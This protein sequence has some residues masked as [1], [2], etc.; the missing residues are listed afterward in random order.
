MIAAPVAAVKHCAC[1]HSYQSYRCQCLMPVSAW[2][3]AR[4][5][6]AGP[7]DPVHQGD[8]ADVVTA[9]HH[10]VGVKRLQLKSSGPSST[11]RH[12][13]SSYTAPLP[14]QASALLHRS[15]QWRDKPDTTCC[16]VSASVGPQVVANCVCPLRKKRST[17]CT[18][19]RPTPLLLQTKLPEFQAICS[20]SMP[21]SPRR[22]GRSPGGSQ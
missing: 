20:E 1:P 18:S 19:R 8:R 16:G 12:T 15:P 2:P 17:L 5:L 22:I 9:A 10:E 6:R 4:K 14:S 13:K 3:S 7:D 21:G 11:T